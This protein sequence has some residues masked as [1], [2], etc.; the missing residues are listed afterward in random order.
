MYKHLVL[1]K[2]KE[3]AN[4][5]EKDELAYE[6]RQRLNTLPDIISEIKGR[7]AVFVGNRS[8]DFAEG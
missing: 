5:M 2:L 4:G 8:A 6:V 7:I 1:W 3:T